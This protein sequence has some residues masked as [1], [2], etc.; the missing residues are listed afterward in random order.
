MRDL[1][2]E[3]DARLAGTAVVDAAPQPRFDDLVSELASA[4]W[5]DSISI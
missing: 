4:A 3:V 5:G 2:S 1:A